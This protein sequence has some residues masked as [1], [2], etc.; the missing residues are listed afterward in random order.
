MVSMVN[1][2][3]EKLADSDAEPNEQDGEDLEEDNDAPLSDEDL[4]EFETDDA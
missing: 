1:S 3:E 4:E 2:E